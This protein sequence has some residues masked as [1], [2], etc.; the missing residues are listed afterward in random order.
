MHY[1]IS[2]WQLKG[3]RPDGSEIEG[4]VFPTMEEGQ[5]EAFLLLLEWPDNIYWV[6]AVWDAA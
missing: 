2:G 4:D 1:V 5:H 6:E 3:E